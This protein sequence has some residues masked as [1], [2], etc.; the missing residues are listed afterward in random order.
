MAD[1]AALIDRYGGP[2]RA[3]NIGAPGATP[4]PI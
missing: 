3:K 4:A 2:E 1:Q